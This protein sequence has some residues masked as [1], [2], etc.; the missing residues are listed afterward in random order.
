MVGDTLGSYRIL[1]RLGQGRTGTVYLAERG[2]DGA[3]F[4][5]KVVHPEVCADP[6]RRAAVLRAAARRRELAHPA[7]A[8][9]VEILAE[10]QA[11]AIVSEAAEGEP[12][13]DR[14]LSGPLPAREAARIAAELAGAVAAAHE[15]G[16]AGL[17][18]RPSQVL[19][20]TGSRPGAVRWVGLEPRTPGGD[21]LAQLRMADIESVMSLLRAMLRGRDDLPEELR[22]IL[23]A[24]E[25]P[26]GDESYRSAAELARDLREVAGPARRRWPRWVAAAVIIA[27]PVALVI[28]MG[29]AGGLGGA[30]RREPGVLAVLPFRTIS[31]DPELSYLGTGLA[32]A[33]TSSLSRYGTPIVR[34]MSA[35]IEA[36]ADHPNPME[37]ARRLSVS[38]LLKGSCEPAPGG[39]RATVEILDT[40][41]GAAVWRRTFETRADDPLPVEEAIAQAAHTWLAPEAPHPPSPATPAGAGHTARYLY[42]L[43]RGRMADYESRPLREAITLLERATVTE[44]AYEPAQAALAEA[45][46]N[47]FLGGISSDRTWLARAVAAGRRAV[48]LDD[49]DAAAHF[50]LGYALLYS[51]EPVS[52]AREILNALRIDPS[53]SG[54]LRVMSALLSQAGAARPARLLRDRA[55]RLDPVR[56]PGWSD[57]YLATAEG[58]VSETIDK[59]EVEVARRRAAGRPTEIPV[60][61]LGFLAFESGDAPSGLRWAAMLEDLSDNEVYAD[62]V[63]LLALA[64]MGD[65][66]A[67]ERILEKNRDVYW[68]DWEYS[69]WIARALALLGR[70]EASLA[71]LARCAAL[72]GYDASALTRGDFF[73]G[74]SD[75]PLYR[76]AALTVTSRARQI[77]D[78]AAGAGYL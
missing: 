68:H 9:V 3:R 42:L 47:M 62:M 4:A 12:L 23:E 19:I 69:L 55:V 76:E 1:T 70:R 51:G 29:R 35:V 39:T 56:A 73:S 40:A 41:T 17:D 31:D 63:R 72:G 11:L 8:R 26:C 43:A 58:R 32:D 67:V 71:W 22:G 6:A 38:L 75:D 14:M 30:D 25:I 16:M 34:S 50:S 46:A 13:S 37:A 48:R 61:T 52:A 59:L 66:V 27:I 20:A 78:L 54:A 44:P 65:A 7:I 28:A 10:P 24:S 33:I 49:S 53:H 60:Q 5:L 15:A 77:L 64:R 45:S 21:D 18:P 36:T 2:T 74:V 57:A